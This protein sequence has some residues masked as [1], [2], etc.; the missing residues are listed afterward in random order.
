MKPIQQRKQSLLFG[1]VSLLLSALLLASCMPISPLS[2]PLNGGPTPPVG[3]PLAAPGAATV[4]AS[5]LSTTPATNTVATTETVARAAPTA[6]PAA[7][8]AADTVQAVA[9]LGGLASATSAVTSTAQITAPAPSQVAIPKP[10]P[11]INPITMAAAL[12]CLAQGDV[13][14]ALALQNTNVR[15]DAA[16][17]ACRIGRIPRGTLVRVTGD[18]SSQPPAGVTAAA[19]PTPAASTAAQIGYNEDVLPILQRNCNTCHSAVAKSMELQVTSY[20]GIMQGSA[21][22]PVILPGDATGSLLWQ[23]VSTGKMPLIGSLTSNEKTLIKDWI[24]Q[25]APEDRP[26][27]A[28]APGDQNTTAS[29]SAAQSQ[30]WLNVAADDVNPVNDVCAA[31][32]ANPAHVVSSQLLLPI[33]CAEKPDAVALD[34]LRVKM[35]LPVLDAANLP[36]APPAA[37]PADLS[38][39]ASSSIT[40]TTD[41]PPLTGAAEVTATAATTAGTASTQ[42]AAPVAPVQAAF[43]SS[44]ASGTGITTPALGLGAPTDDDPWLIPRGGLC[45][46]RKLPDNERGITAMTFAPDGRLFLAF[47]SKLTGEDVDQI[48]LYDAYHPSR[49][50]GVIDSSAMQGLTEILQ[51]SPR[52]TGMDWQDGVLYISRAGEV[53]LIADGGTYEALAGGFAVNSQLFHANNGLV[54]ANGWLYV[55]AGGV[56]DGYS[57]GPMV[58]IDEA[59]A[60]QIASG[61]NPLAARI[62][63]APL[64]AL[65]SQRSSSVFSTAARG[66]RNP[67][68][69]TVDGVGR[70]W[71]TDN[72]ATNVPEDVSAGDEVN[73]LDPATIGGDEA[74]SP[75]YGFPLAILQPKEWYAPPAVVLP[76][77]A[78]PTGITWAL[79]TIYY[80]QYGKD[81][82]LYRLGV[83]S[84][85]NLIS[86]R[87]MLGW[88]ILSLAT[89]PD[90]ALW[91]GMGDGSLFR[92]T[93]GCS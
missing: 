28:S 93:A 23:L 66:T 27:A 74:G 29:P 76:N 91:V 42:S 10:V 11:P 86:E 16:P 19:T 22:G 70:I 62:V 55:S 49:S 17:N 1:P 65:T 78:A 9:G 89:A 25:G 92:L 71:F 8:P 35:G 53:G 82:G 12:D 4:V 83:N 30:L 48:I 14:Y 84:A 50:I 88:P 44:A 6:E 26:L 64:D 69:I 15:Q 41:A 67:Y 72:G 60:Q 56:R 52:I 24:D 32:L 40:N 7:E 18:A 90:G 61:G 85:G 5:T 59:T 36:S 3:A 20:A 63:R 21:R 47:D 75:Y 46:E 80:A 57:D 87:V 58:D 31:P 38:T 79:G 43:A 2:F 81:P 39:A 54:I 33:V 37:A 45:I 68:G 13:V 51:E 34:H 73:L 77:T